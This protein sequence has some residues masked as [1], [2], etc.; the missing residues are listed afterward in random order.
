MTVS[1]KPKNIIESHDEDPDTPNMIT[2]FAMP[3]VRMF[4]MNY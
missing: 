1:P 4:L 3:S 2:L